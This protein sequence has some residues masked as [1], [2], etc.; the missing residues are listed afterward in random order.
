MAKVNTNQLMSGMKAVSKTIS[1][2]AKGSKCTTTAINTR[3]NGPMGWQVAMVHSHGLMVV[4]TK[5]HLSM[6]RKKVMVL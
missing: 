5:V 6:V 4:H 3:V 2:T 1:N